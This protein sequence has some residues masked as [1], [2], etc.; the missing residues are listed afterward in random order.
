MARIAEEFPNDVR[1]VFRH[2]PLMSIHDKAALATQAA[3]AAGLQGK[4]WEMHDLLFETQQEWK[5]MSVQ[6][7]ETW[8]NLQA[9]SMGMEAGK[10]SEDL[11][12]EALVAKAK[13]A[14]EN[15]QTLGLPGTPFLVMNDQIWPDNLPKSYEMIST[16]IKLTLLEQRQFASYPPMTIDSG[17]S[18]QA[19]LH[20]S[21]GDI[22][23]KLFADTAPLA[24]NNFVFLARQG[25]Y[26][27]V[28]FHRVIAGFMAQ[29]GDPTGTGYG[30][31]GY[32][33]RDEIHSGDVFDR[34]GQVAMANSGPDT[35]GSQFF[36]T[37]GATDQLN[38]KHTIFGEVVS[39]MDVVESITIRDPSSG[40]P[41]PDGD[42]IEQVEIIEK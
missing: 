38:G 8:L 22:T 35:N 12:S 40:E 33:F 13:Q 24:V 21:K 28:S 2:F 30:G 37:L 14:W 25:W 3:E 27:G 4:F 23:L 9:A 1:L 11:V 10:F 7:F 42:V 32:A 26:D 29:T 41:L 31:P 18:Y 39:G 6:D 5:G 34:A 17:K 20:T 19:V 16:V 36:V 15:G